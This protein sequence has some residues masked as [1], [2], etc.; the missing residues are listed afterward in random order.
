VRQMGFELF[1]QLGV[2]LGSSEKSFE[3]HI[4]SPLG[5]RLKNGA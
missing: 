1:R 4:G 3:I 5:D 2:F